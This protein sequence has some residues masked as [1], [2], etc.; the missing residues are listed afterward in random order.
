[1]SEI[2]LSYVITTRNKLPYLKELMK[3]LLENV[4]ADEEI[5]V[6]DGAVGSQHWD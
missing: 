2:K 1:M 5:V 6:A 3:W 4:Q